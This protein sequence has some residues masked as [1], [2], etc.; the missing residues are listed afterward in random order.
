MD[1]SGT[2]SVLIGGETGVVLGLPGEVVVSNQPKSQV[3]WSFTRGP[4]AGTSAAVVTAW[5]APGAPGI[6]DPSGSPAMSSA[7]T[8]RTE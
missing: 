7:H 2:N 3:L 5:S 1:D 4:I 8:I 6:L